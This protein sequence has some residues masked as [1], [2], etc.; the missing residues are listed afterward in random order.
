MSTSLRSAPATIRR[1]PGRSGQVHDEA[2][3]RRKDLDEIGNGVAVRGFTA[4]EQRLAVIRKLSRTPFPAPFRPEFYETPTSRSFGLLRI[5]RPGTATAGLNL[6][7][8]L[9]QGRVPG[10]ASVVVN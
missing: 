7:N 3:S 10:F 1:S 6:D 9:H 4:A 8:G 5:R 2:K